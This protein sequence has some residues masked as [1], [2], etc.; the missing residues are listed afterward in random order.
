MSD[1]DSRD[2]RFR[3]V[4]GSNTAEDLNDLLVEASPWSV[5]PRGGPTGQRPYDVQSWARGV[6]T[7]DGSPR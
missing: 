4:S 6:C 7:S 5:R 1:E 3:F 2:D